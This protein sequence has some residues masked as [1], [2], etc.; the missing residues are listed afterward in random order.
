MKTQEIAVRNNGE[1]PGFSAGYFQIG[2]NKDWH[3]ERKANQKNEHH[4]AQRPDNYCYRSLPGQGRLNGIGELKI[5]RMTLVFFFAAPDAQG[6]FNHG[7]DKESA[8]R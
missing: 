8:A 2:K 4:K 7:E 6:R 5:H 3:C 1:H